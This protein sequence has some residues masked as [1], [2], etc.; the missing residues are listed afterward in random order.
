M[1]HI[2]LHYE[3]YCCNISHIVAIC[4]IAV[5]MLHS[6]T[7]CHIAADMLHSAAQYVIICTELDSAVSRPQVK[8]RLFPRKPL[9]LCKPLRFVQFGQ[10]SCPAGE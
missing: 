8:N 7:I 5:D 3:A 1:S 2:A 4:Y 9:P 6:L 10:E